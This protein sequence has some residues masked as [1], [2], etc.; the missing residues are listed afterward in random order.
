ML[1]AHILLSCPVAPLFEMIH[2]QGTHK[3]FCA[4]AVLAVILLIY[5]CVRWRKTRK[6]R[7]RSQVRSFLFTARAAPAILVHMLC[8]SV[9][10]A[11]N[12]QAM[13]ML[14]SY[15]LHC[16]GMPVW[17]GQSQHKRSMGKAA[18]PELLRWQ[19]PAYLV[20]ALAC[21]SVWN[22]LTALQVMPEDGSPDNDPGAFSALQITPTTRVHPEAQSDAPQSSDPAV[23]SST[24]ASPRTATAAPR[25]TSGASAVVNVG[26]PQE[27]FPL[28]SQQYPPVAWTWNPLRE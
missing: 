14:D 7:R 24:L 13:S 3:G 28:P 1:H 23:S 2:I 11:P 10:T 26:P 17:Q 6:T 22:G 27:K 16:N 5:V 9:K 25:P 19:C 20:S 15:L 8:S 4:S 12:S 21:S 18:S